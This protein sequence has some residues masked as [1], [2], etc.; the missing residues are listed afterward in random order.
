VGCNSENAHYSDT[1]TTCVTGIEDS[2]SDEA[3]AL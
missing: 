1:L 2:L 3:Q